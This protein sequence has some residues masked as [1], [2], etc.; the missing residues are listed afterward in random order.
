[1]PKMDQ[2]KSHEEAWADWLHEPFPAAASIAP[3]LDY[4]AAKTTA[5][6]VPIA[7]AIPASKKV[8]QIDIK[9]PKIKAP[10]NQAVSRMR[11]VL[12][13]KIANKK[14]A[15]ALAVS[16]ITVAVGLNA[17]NFA[18]IHTTDKSPAVSAQTPYSSGSKQ[19]TDA[20]AKPSFTVLAP[21]DK[22]QLGQ[23]GTPKTAYDGTRNTFS[24][25]DT[26]LGT[27]LTVSEQPLPTKYG[28]PQDAAAKI[29]QSLHAKEVIGV[30]NGAAFME[31]DSKSNSQTIVYAKSDVIVFIQSPFK[32]EA[33]NWKYYLDGL[34]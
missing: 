9:L 28:S 1:M 10:G 29:A 8:V 5:L 22:A 26:Y 14:V 19:T 33:L 15:G 16:V 2:T 3:D 31:T 25:M 17:H 11:T 18:S 7:P 30:S 12:L 24:F 20:P 4:A 34:Q 13:S 23:V 32:K 21:R 6:D 27:E